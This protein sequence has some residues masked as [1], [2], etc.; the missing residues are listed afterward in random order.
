MR[1]RRFSIGRILAAITLTLSIA[2]AAQ[3]VEIKVTVQNLAP[4]NGNFLTPV[5]V[6]FH[7]GGFDIYD[8]GAPATMGL[9]RIAEDGDPGPL[10]AEFMTSQPSGVDG[11]LDGIGPIGP[12]QSVSLFLSI[13]A[14]LNPYFSYASMIIPSNDAFIANGDPLAHSLFDMSGA[15]IGASFI[16]LGTGARD[17]GTEVNDEVPMNTAFFGQT[18]PNTGVTEGGTVQVHG[19][20]IPG[21][22]I[23]SDPMFAGADFTASG[24]QIAQIT[25][26]Q[27]PEPSTWLLLAAGLAGVAWTRRRR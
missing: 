3:A 27:V 22:P 20:F 18:T 15:F 16:V 11:V 2:A 17:A 25:V 14:L 10:S 1:S 19:G 7:D 13:D 9:E 5:W 23:L 21:G 24:Y 8:I 6:G 4:A 26:E 12:G